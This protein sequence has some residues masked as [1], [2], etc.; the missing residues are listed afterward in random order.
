MRR[1]V[2]SGSFDPVTCGHVDIFERAAR[3]FDELTVC[4]FHNRQKEGF[5]SV[6]ERVRLLREATRHIDGLKVTAFSGLLADFLRQEDI[7]FIVRG[8]RSVAD[9]EYETPAE[10][11]NHQLGNQVETV[12]LLTNPRYGHISSSAI[13]ELVAFG[14]DASGLVPPCVAEALAG[15]TR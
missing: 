3:L 9:L 11:L 4:V 7:H 14:A 10:R 5:F 1:G 15:K 12:F 13:R 6:E 8:L 2:C